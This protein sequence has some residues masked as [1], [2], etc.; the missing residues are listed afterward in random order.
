MQTI[1][2]KLKP[3]QLEVQKTAHDQDLIEVPK[4]ARLDR[5]AEHRLASQGTPWSANVGAP[6]SS[7]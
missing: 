6:A 1:V 5:E 2:E 7:Y 3:A 4:R